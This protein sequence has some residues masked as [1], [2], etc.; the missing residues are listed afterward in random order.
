MGGATV[1]AIFKSKALRDKKILLL[2]GAPKR[3]YS[4]PKEYSNRVNA[5]NHSSKDLFEQ[6]EI[7]PM[8]KEAR[9]KSIQGM[10]IWDSRESQTISFE[11]S[12]LGQ[13]D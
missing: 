10:H 12:D 8:I 2:E 3:E 6:I 5:L 7:W 13:E 1:A 9:I 4:V 11:A